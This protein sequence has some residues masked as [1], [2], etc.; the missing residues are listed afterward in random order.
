MQASCFRK[1]ADEL[2]ATATGKALPSWSAGNISSTV[3]FRIT[4]D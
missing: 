4:A 3:N 1:I 2:I